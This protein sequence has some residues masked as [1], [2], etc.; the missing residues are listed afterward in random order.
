[1]AGRQ[2]HRHRRLLDALVTEV[3]DGANSALEIAYTRDASGPMASL[4]LGD[5]CLAAWQVWSV[6][7]GA[8]LSGTIPAVSALPGRARIGAD[9]N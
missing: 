7:A 2:R 1:M 8:R 9:P 3:A 4:A 6:L 5:P